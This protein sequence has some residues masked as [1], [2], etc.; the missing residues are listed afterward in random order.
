M[1][2]YQV[3]DK[4][5]KRRDGQW[6]R[7]DGTVQ[8]QKKDGSIIP[9]FEAVSRQSSKSVDDICYSLD[10]EQSSYELLSKAINCQED[11]RLK[12]RMESKLFGMRR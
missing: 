2:I 11:S 3:I 12:G 4:A 10:I 6:V 9:F 7:K 8:F 1:N 5:S